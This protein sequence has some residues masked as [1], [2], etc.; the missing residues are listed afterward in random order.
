MSTA[1][2]GRETSAHPD[3]VPQTMTRAASVMTPAEML[4]LAIERGSGLDMVSKLMDLQER[5][6]ASEAQKAFRSAFAAF[7]AEA[8][9]VIKNKSVS[10]GP[11]KG[12]SYAELHS[13]VN[14]VTP[15]LS[16][17]G[18]SASWDIT[19]DEKDWIE[20]ACKIEHVHGHS[21]IVSM[22]GPP[23][24]GGAKN[25]IQA[26]ASTITYLE[27]YTLKAACGLAEQDDD[28]D[29][30]ARAR[31]G[32]PSTILDAQLARLRRIIEET[33]S[34]EQKLCAYFK[35][36][37]LASLDQ[38]DFSEAINLLEARRTAK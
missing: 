7:K 17:H 3:T 33:R 15:A 29:G 18:L 38:R 27:R 11:L 10:D 16:R 28:A 5:W 26:R 25:A 36:G 14:A 32:E 24:A 13:F 37:D 4:S 6:E 21:K 1:M 23:D 19:R 12:R 8:V 9:T 34:S 20:V 2:I 35:V 30:R 31:D 22:G